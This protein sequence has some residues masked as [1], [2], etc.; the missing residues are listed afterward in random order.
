MF[1]FLTKAELLQ[2]GIFSLIHLFAR[3]VLVMEKL[4][5]EKPKPTLIISLLK[6]EY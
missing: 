6:V 1:Q 4:E 2:E 3:E 5:I